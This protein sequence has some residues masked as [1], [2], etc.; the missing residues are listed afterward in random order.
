MDIFKYCSL[1]LDLCARG[2]V[3]T[4][5]A[6]RA[7]FPRFE[8]GRAL[9]AFVAICALFFCLCL[10][11]FR[12]FMRVIEVRNVYIGAKRNFIIIIG[13]RRYYNGNT[14]ILCQVQEND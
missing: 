5:V 2:T 6:C 3:A 4:A 13:A 1:V 12:H 9:D 7:T 11:I 14:R 8:S 10:A